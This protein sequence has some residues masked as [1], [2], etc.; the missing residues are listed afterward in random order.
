MAPSMTPS[1][2][3]DQISPRLLYYGF[4]VQ[5]YDATSTDSVY[6]KLDYGVCHSIRISGHEGKQ[7]LKYRY[8]IR[9]DPE[10]ENRLDF[11]IDKSGDREYLR[12]YCGLLN[13]DDILQKILTERELIVN[14]CGGYGNYSHYIEG[15]RRK[16]QHTKG[17]WQKAKELE[18]LPNGIAVVAK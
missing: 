17:F 6:L 14:N 8:N 12:W 11:E 18:L 13:I 16:G 10:W 1:Q 4:K 5:R 7:H 9:T 3:A 2:I 15:A